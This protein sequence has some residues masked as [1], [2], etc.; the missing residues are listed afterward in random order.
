MPGMLCFA[1][2]KFFLK[3]KPL[4]K[5]IRGSARPIFVRIWSQIKDLTF[6]FQSL[7]GRCQGNQF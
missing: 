1:G 3:N 2:V 6:F 7:K 4:S 5:I